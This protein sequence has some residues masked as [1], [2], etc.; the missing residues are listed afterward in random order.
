MFLA[1]DITHFRDVVR[2]LTL[3]MLEIMFTSVPLVRTEEI[4]CVVC[5]I[6]LLSLV[7][8]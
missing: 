1:G 4:E 2:P 5:I 3:M 6:N 7:L 8:Q